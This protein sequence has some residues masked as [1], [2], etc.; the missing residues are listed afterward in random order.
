M[1]H[2]SLLFGYIIPTSLLT[3]VSLAL[4]T[5]QQQYVQV[6]R[7][8][9]RLRELRHT[10]SH[11]VQY[12]CNGVQHLYSVG[13]SSFHQVKSPGRSI[14]VVKGTAH[15]RLREILAKATVIALA[16]FDVGRSVE[17]RRNRIAK[18]PERLGTGAFVSLEG[19]HM[20][21]HYGRVSAIPT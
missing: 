21:T 12:K 16:S 5:V 17:K 20:Y 8:R 10:Q 4:Q 9:A 7:A 11:M 19:F 1:H 15:T 3:P 14:L 13:N 18:Y 6:Q 2:I